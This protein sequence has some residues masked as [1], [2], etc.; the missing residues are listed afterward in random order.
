MATKS[1]KSNQPKWQKIPDNQVR[2]LWR[3]GTKHCGKHGEQITV[4]P[5]FYANSG[6]PICS[7]CGND[8]S[9]HGTEVLV[10]TTGDDPTVTNTLSIQ[11]CLDATQIHLKV[12]RQVQRQSAK[13]P[14]RLA[15]DVADVVDGMAVTVAKLAAVV[16]NGARDQRGRRR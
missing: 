2:Q 1:T 8:L 10:P 12:V 6:L 5:S 13:L 16:K 11:E 4:D 15:N 7:E 14:K 3:C 9:Y